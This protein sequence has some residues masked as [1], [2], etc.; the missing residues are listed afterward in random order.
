MLFLARRE[1]ILLMSFGLGRKKSYGFVGSSI[2]IWFGFFFSF[3]KF[4]VFWMGF[5]C[6]VL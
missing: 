2:V 1:A 3:V 5:H 4:N 6:I